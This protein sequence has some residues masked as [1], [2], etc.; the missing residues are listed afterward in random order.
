[1]NLTITKVGNN[2]PSPF[3]KKG[4]DQLIKATLGITG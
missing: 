1:M 2:D 4:N 3:Q